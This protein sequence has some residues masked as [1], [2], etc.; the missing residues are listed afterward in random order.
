MIISEIQS[1]VDFQISYEVEQQVSH[2]F[3]KRSVRELW[4][5]INDVEPPVIDPV[6][7]QLRS[8]VMEQL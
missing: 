3:T 5:Q 6:Y 8:D 4:R 2:R 1:L 7:D